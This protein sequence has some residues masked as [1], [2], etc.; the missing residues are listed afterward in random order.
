[1]ECLDAVLSA[2]NTLLN[3]T[4]MMTNTEEKNVYFLDIKTDIKQ[5]T[6]MI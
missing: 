5:Y 1:M 6:A 2:G 4:D 3:Y